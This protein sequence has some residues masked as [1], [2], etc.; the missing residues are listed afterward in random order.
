[1]GSEVGTV[2]KCVLKRDKFWI[3]YNLKDIDASITGLQTLK[4]KSQQQKNERM[5]LF[6]K[7]WSK[8]I[9]LIHSVNCHNVENK[10]NINY[11]KE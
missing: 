10:T 9:K 2:E 5:Q 6:E 8:N 3:K 11:N 4:Q 1:M 7:D